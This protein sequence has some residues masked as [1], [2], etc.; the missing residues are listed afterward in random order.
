LRADAGGWS[1][2]QRSLAAIALKGQRGTLI[3]IQRTKQP[4]F[5]LIRSIKSSMPCRAEWI[6]KGAVNTVSTEINSYQHNLAIAVFQRTSKGST[7]APQDLD[8]IFKSRSPDSHPTSAH[9]TG[10][11]ILS[12]G[13]KKY[14]FQ[15]EYSDPN[16]RILCNEFA[17]QGLGDADLT[18]KWIR[19]IMPLLAAAAALHLLLE[20]MLY[21]FR[22]ARG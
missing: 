11:A 1:P 21:G 8:H 22:F 9:R 4:T 6:A 15:S 10:R 14:L 2:V 12:R 18:E 16:H 13:G 19:R 7:N 17:L 5:P 20:E 3:D